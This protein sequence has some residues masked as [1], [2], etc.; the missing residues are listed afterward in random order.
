MKMVVLASALAFVFAMEL[1]SFITFLLVRSPNSS[2]NARE[3]GRS[4]ASVGFDHAAA[5]FLAALITLLYGVTRR[6][7]RWAV[8]A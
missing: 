8:K 6:L 2:D 3:A 5:L 4:I 7:Y 1:Y